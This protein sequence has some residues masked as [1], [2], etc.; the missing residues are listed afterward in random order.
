MVGSIFKNPASFGVERRLGIVAATCSLGIPMNS[1]GAAEPP[2]AKAGS[3]GQS[4]DETNN[5]NQLSVDDKI[6]LAKHNRLVSTTAAQTGK[7]PNILVIWVMILDGI[8]PV[9]TT[10]R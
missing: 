8:T 3:A 10:A 9:H 2:E 4:S 5:R 7:K 6:A 1:V